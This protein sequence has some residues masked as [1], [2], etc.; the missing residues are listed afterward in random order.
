VFSLDRKTFRD[1]R[2][3]QCEKG[4]IR[5]EG[6]RDRLRFALLRFRAKGKE[7]FP[8][9]VGVVKLQISP[10]Q[11]ELRKVIEAV[12]YENLPWPTDRRRIYNEPYPIEMT[13]KVA[14][15]SLPSEDRIIGFVYSIVGGIE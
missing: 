5:D 10:E 15:A 14:K 11:D 3:C 4:N 13:E 1:R 7:L 9:P 6:G 12:L 8:L 2:K